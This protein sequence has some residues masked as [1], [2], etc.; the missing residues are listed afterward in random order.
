MT[1]G[2]YQ[3]AF[4]GT[5]GSDY[6]GF[7]ARFN[8]A[9]SGS[10]SLIYSTYLGP[11]YP[12]LDA[13]ASDSSGRRIRDRQSTS[14]AFPVT[15]GASTTADMSRADGGVYVT[16]LNPTGTALVY[17]AYLGYG[18]GYGIAVDTLRTLT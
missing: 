8:P 9:A 12:N 14:S 5:V 2:A 3:G 6:N 4:S 17:S 11:A 13:L 1:A 15:S 16:K 10:A 18:N 7:V